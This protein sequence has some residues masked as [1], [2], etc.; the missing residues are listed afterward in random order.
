MKRIQLVINNN[1]K[2]YNEEFF[3]KGELKS[4]LN[5]LITKLL[6]DHVKIIERP[7]LVILI[8]ITLIIKKKI[9]LAALFWYYGA[10]KVIPEKFGVMF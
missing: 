4:I 2:K 7:L 8:W 5:V 6:A 3:I 9:K 1:V 10:I